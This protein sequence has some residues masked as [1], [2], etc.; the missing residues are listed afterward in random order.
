MIGKT[1]VFVTAL[2]FVVSS[3]VLA[4]R[5][6]E[7]KVN[8]PEGN[9]K[10]EVEANCTQCHG[11]GQVANAGHSRKDWETAIYMMVNAGA[12]VP[13]GQIPVVT[14]Y[15]TKNFPEKPLPP[16]D[17]LPGGVKVTFQE[18]DLPTPGSRPHDPLAAADGT[19]WYTGHMAGLLG[20]IDPKTGKITEFRPKTPNVGPH[21]LTQDKDGNIWFTENFKGAIGELFTKTGEF[22]EYPL[23]G[24]AR[25][26]HTPIFDQKGMLWFTVQGAN[27]VARLNPKTG[28]IKVVTS[29]TSRSNPY[30][31]VITSKGVPTFVEFGAPK[32][33]Q[34]DPDTMAIKEY[35]LPDPGARPRRIA[36]SPDD[37]IWYSDF[38]R[39]YLGRLDL[40]TGQVK[41]WP[42]PSGP[43]S[44]PYAI[45]WLKDA[46]WYVESNTKPN[47]LVRF[48]PKTEKFQSWAI[49]GGG[50]VVRNM[51]VTKDGNLALAES[52]VNKVALAEV[53]K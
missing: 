18:W 23:P 52:G 30:G 35:P 26:P 46:V 47:A 15:L 27:M 49:P 50:G 33:G 9:G 14:D 32:V 29:P 7:Q 51:M 48:D 44:Q 6:P 28:D 42:S 5:G 43:K 16:A 45:S 17:I 11:L 22:K 41:E 8:L 19:I 10:A 3:A 31:M 53:G 21:G 36:I 34:I 25:D 13:S 2:G 12:K 4:Q 37:T 1:L 39:G 20:H 40:S 38:A 24:G